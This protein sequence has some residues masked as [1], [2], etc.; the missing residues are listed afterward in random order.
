M[1]N[2]EARSGVRGLVNVPL[3]AAIVAAVLLSAN[4]RPGIAVDILGTR[5]ELQNLIRDAALLLIA[6]LSLWLTPG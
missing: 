5:L 2:R 6:L 4:W 3:I 1:P